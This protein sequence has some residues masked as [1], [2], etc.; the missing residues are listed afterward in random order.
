MQ[1]S[2][3]PVTPAPNR[4]RSAALP[5]SVTELPV[6]VT[7]SRWASALL[8]ASAVAPSSSNEL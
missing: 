2:Y 8:A 4:A 1:A 7:R 3:G 6:M 5:V